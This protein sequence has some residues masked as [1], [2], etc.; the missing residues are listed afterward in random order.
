LE[1]LDRTGLDAGGAHGAALLLQQAIQNRP[2]GGVRARREP[3]DKPDGTDA[4]GSIGHF[5]IP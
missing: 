4:D 2:V 3:L 5:R 1:I